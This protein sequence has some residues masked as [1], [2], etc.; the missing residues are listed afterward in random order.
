MITMCLGV[1]LLGFILPRTLCFLDLVDYFLS[2]VREVFSYYLFT[3]FLRSFL[4]LSSF[5]DPY[6]VNVDVFNVPEVSSA[7]FSSVAQSC[8]T[9]CDPMN[10]SMPGL[11]V[12]H[13]PPELT[14]THAH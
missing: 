8:P 5:W 6:N 13:K 1:F 9:L 12:H 7:K 10:C 4:S 3:Y 2:H 14:Q 11:P